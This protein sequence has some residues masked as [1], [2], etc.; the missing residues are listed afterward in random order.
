MVRALANRGVRALV[1]EI[2]KGKVSIEHQSYLF[3][4]SYAY[5]LFLFS[6]LIAD[7]NNSNI[8]IQ[9]ETLKDSM[10]YFMKAEDALSSS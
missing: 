3:S 10:T 6:R 9:F 2:R 7:K 8:N 5:C 1:G 4:R